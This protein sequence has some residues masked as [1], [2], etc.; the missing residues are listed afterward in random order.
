MLICSLPGRIS[1][2]EPVT[3][4]M[5]RSSSGQFKWTHAE[6]EYLASYWSLPLQFRFFVPKW[7]IVLGESKADVLAPMA[8]FKTIFPL[9]ILMSLWVVLLLSIGQIRR[10]LVPLERL[11][12]GTRRI[13][14]RDFE[15]RAAV[16]SGDE[17]EELAGSFNAMASRLG[18]QFNTL[19]TMA[20]IDRAILSA[21]DTRKI[22]D[23][24]LTRMRGS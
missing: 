16:T 9:V 19:A 22:V 4:D 21:L 10:S 18:R 17:F 24:V 20:E 11:Q 6:K 5:T 3:L 8:N 1:F 14:A 15:S 13:A 2:P 7:T 12:E 23:V